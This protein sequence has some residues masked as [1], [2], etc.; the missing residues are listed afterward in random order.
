M[1][2]VGFLWGKGI[3]ADARRTPIQAESAGTGT[4]ATEEDKTLSPY[5]FVK[6]ED[7]AVDPLPLKATRTA[8]QIAG[9]IAE[10]TVVQVYRN[11][12]TRPIE[13]V[14][15]FPASTRAAVYGMKMTV[16]ERVI[17]AEIQKREEARKAYEEARQQGKTASLLEQHRPNVFQM[18]VANILPGDEIRTE[19]RYTELLTR[20]DGVYEFVYP[21][22]VGPRY[23]NEPESGAPPSEKW[24]QNPY[25]HQ[26]EAPPYEFDIQVRLDAGMPIREMTCPSH[27]TQVRYE[28]PNRAQVSLGPAE[29]HGGNRDFILK[30]RLSGKEVEP[31]LLLYEGKE[32]NFFLLLVEPPQA[33]PETMI[34]PR[35][36]VFI[37]DVSGSMHG[38]PLETAKGLLKDLLGGLRPRDVFNVLLFS[39]GSQLMAERSLPA[40]PEN[41]R[42]ALELIGRQRGGGG[43]ELLPALERAMKLPAHEGMARTL[44]VVTDGFVR[45]EPEVFD[46]IRN[47]LGQ[48]N[49]FPFGIGSSVNRHLIEGMARIGMGEPFIVTKPEEAPRQAERFR[50]LIST[51]LLTRLDFKTDGFS[52]DEVEPPRL[53][54]VFAQRPVIV[55]GKWKGSPRG[56]ISLHGTLGTQTYDR[57][58]DVAAYKPSASNLA[59]KYLWARS[60]ITRLSDYNRLLASDR[61]TGEITDLGLRYSLLTSY[62]SFVAVD[63]EVRRKEGESATVRQPL[64]LPEGV[65]DYAVGGGAPAGIAP[66]SMAVAP[67]PSRGLRQGVEG[68]SEDARGVREAKEV[69]G[70]KM[71]KGDIEARVRVQS[72]T[73]G[74]GLNESQVRSV[75]EASEKGL[76]DCLRTLLSREV[77]E[78]KVKL[79]WVVDKKGRVRDLKITTPAGMTREIEACL[80]GQILAWRFVNRGGTRA[81]A[82]TLELSVRP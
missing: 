52:A 14:Y 37:V 47:S 64:P 62:T 7:P 45:V 11:E 42:N 31:G 70:V 29:K 3:P 30:Y 76:L 5:F 75:V 79:T 6:S 78:W 38:F 22:V 18:N 61:R 13:A 1:V 50:R 36:T 74:P 44:V 33:P 12:G 26:G 46:L 58:L 16:G 27:G 68:M 53:P 17:E 49:V 2:S 25:L 66:M 54:D 80:Q 65:S 67:L 69:S 21:T 8:V 72:L 59:L 57:R 56:T 77:P 15:V 71:K 24:S 20:T 81:S 19:L 73:V 82:V 41:L 23:S 9:V 63:S 34:P 32:E 55:F 10:V 40:T 28:G 39:G 48:A 60:R 35:E 51:P 43:T 4:A